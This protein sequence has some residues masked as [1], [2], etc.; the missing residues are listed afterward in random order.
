[1]VFFV[2]KDSRNYNTRFK[3]QKDF[4]IIPALTGQAVVYGITKDSN[5][6][7]YS[8]PAYKDIRYELN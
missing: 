6:K 8:I 3:E 2:N 7:G 1:L 5:I 4:F